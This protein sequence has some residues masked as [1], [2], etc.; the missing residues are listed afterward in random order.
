VDEPT[1]PFGL[2][3]VRGDGS[4]IVEADE[5]VERALGERLRKQA[6][7]LG[8]SVASLFHV[9]YAQVLARTT[10]REDVVFGT[11]LFGRMQGGEGADRVVGPFIN[12]LPIRLQVGRAG[13]EASVRQAHA[14][15]TELLR[16]EHASL[17]LAQRCSAVEAPAPL[18][19]A[20][21]NYR[22][23]AAAA[24]SAEGGAARDGEASAAALGGADELSVTLSVDDLGRGGF[25]LTPRCRRPWA[26][27]GCAR[28]CTP[29]WKG[30]P[31]QLEDTPQRPLRTCR[32]SRRPSGA[33]WWRSGTHRRGVPERSCVH[34]LFEAQAART[35]GRGGGRPRE[36]QL[37]YA[38]LNARANRLAHHLR[39]WA[40]ARHPG[41]A[42]RGARARSWWSGCWRS[43]RPAARTCRWTPATRGA[44]AYMLR[45]APRGR[46]DAEQLLDRV[47][48]RDAPPLALDWHAAGWAGSAETNPRAAEL[49]PATWRT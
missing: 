35:P 42:L 33:R 43:S 8:V 26:R 22:H 28:S 21:L 4:G 3:D 7:R 5:V 48:G 18:F 40:W 10:G 13:V 2:L 19:T 16:H 45:T 15:L 49:R 14:S 11:V 46:A 27:S 37:T 20:L 31:G 9:A 39:A 12:T 47:A 23:S 30:L 41:G 29:R 36:D 34:E 1:A 38:E 25:S 17:A 32:C 44:P 6:R 24:P